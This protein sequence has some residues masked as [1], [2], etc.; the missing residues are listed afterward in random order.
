[1]YYHLVEKIFVR[2]SISVNKYWENKE[3]WI[4]TYNPE[5]KQLLNLCIFLMS[6]IHE[7][8][9]VETHWSNLLPLSWEL[10]ITYREWRL[11]CECCSTLPFVWKNF[12]E[13]SEKSI[14]RVIMTMW[15]VIR[16]LKQRNFLP[17]SNWQII[18]RTVL[19]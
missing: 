4:Y 10:W 1:M 13:K 19:I 6:P 9:W 16:R 2:R 11:K 18:H 8:L 17:A 7:N 14:I 5:T 3:S 15:T 12:S